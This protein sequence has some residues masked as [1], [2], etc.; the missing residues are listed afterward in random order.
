M[1][2]TINI[3]KFNI[4]FPGIKSNHLVQINFKAVNHTDVTAF[5]YLWKRPVLVKN[6]EKLQVP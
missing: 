3:K 2:G 4:K 6:V 1:H 5:M